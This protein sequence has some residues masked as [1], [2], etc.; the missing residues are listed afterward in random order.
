MK[1]SVVVLYPRKIWT[2]VN[3]LGLTDEAGDETII[4][5][6]CCFR[7]CFAADTP[8]AARFR[9][10]EFVRSLSPGSVI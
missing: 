2:V 10:K 4:V 9:G 6:G 3:A 8:P 5:P 7:S 1:G